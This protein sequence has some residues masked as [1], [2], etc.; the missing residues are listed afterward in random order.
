MGGVRRRHRLAVLGALLGFLLLAWYAGQ[1]I[2]TTDALMSSRSRD[3]Q[4]RMARQ[5]ECVNQRIESLVPHGA[6]VYFESTD[7]WKQR[8]IDG[9]YPHYQVQ[10]SPLDATYVVSIRI[11]GH[12]C[13]GVHVSIPAP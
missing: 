10:S 9:T 11:V 1:A 2:R 13:R 6:A 12:R 8:A 5:F 4:A 3:P 7:L